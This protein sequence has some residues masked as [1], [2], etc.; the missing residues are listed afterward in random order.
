MDKKY[1]QKALTRF[2]IAIAI[3][4]IFFLSGKYENELRF[5][6]PIMVF[7]YFLLLLG[8]LM[9][10]GFSFSYLIRKSI[11]KTIPKKIQSFVNKNE[12]VYPT[13]NKFIDTLW[14]NV[15]SA[16]FGAIIMFVIPIKIGMDI[17]GFNMMLLPILGTVYFAIYDVL[18]EKLGLAKLKK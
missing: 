5:I 9:L 16:T 6:A 2:L 12:R 3:L 10:I 15:L 11:I 18:D 7:A 17:T 8:G 1:T 4:G 14:W 13:T